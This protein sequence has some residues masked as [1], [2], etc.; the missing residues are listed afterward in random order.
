MIDNLS[1]G[2][3]AAIPKGCRFVEGDI[4]DGDALDR[5]FGSGHGGRAPLRRVQ[6][7]VRFGEGTGRVLRQQHRRDDPSSRADAGE[8]GRSGSSFR[9]APPCTASPRASPS[10]RRRLAAPSTRTGSRSSSSR[11]CSRRAGARG[12]SSSC[13]SATSTPGGST[14][15]HGEHH[16]PESHL[17]PV[18]LDAATGKRR[19]FTIFGNDYDTP[20]WNVHP[21]LHPRPRS[22]RRPHPRARRDEERVSPA[23]STSGAPN[24]SPF[25]TSSRPSSESREN[26]SATRSD[27]AA[28][29]IHPPFSP[30][31]KKAES[32]LGWKKTRSSLEDI[33]RSSYEWR[34]RHP[35]GTRS[36]N[37]S[38]RRPLPLARS[39]RV[40]PSSPS[41]IFRISSGGYPQMNT[42]PSTVSELAFVL[43]LLP[44]FQEVDSVDRLYRLLLAIVTSGQTRRLPPGRCS[45]VPTNRDG[46]I[47]GRYGARARPAGAGRRR[48][49]PEGGFDE[50]ARSVFRN[51][52]QVDA[53]DLTVQGAFVL[54][55]ARAGTGARS[56]RRCGPHTPFSPSG[57]LSEFATD[58]FFEFFGVTSYIA[59]PVEVDR[60]VMAVL[61]VDQRRPRSTTDPPRRSRFSTAS[62][63]RRARRRSGSSRR[64][65]DRR[66]ARILVKLHDS[67]HRASTPVGVRG[68]AQ[69]RRSR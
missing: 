29:E 25:S 7:R 6:R 38:F 50:M 31:R 35:T 48:A 65:N 12:G 67:L 4:R 62:S 33:V 30:R 68:V 58:T 1:T 20:G 13:R 47:R 55:A 27:R 69:G 63:S 53:S 41:A 39:L 61:A 42:A 43:K 57:E 24:R 36:E 8:R 11:R 9:R 26:R 23:R 46:V 28:R 22:R 17:I 2:H 56:S 66:K 59:I 18:V 3:R 52:E 37:R 10:R 5:A 45:S 34:L 16:E 21:R 54:G 40:R 49:H 14:A 64:S 51:F 60:H 15:L 44:L 19:K 32:V